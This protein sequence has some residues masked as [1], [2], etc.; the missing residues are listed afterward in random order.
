MD[1]RPELEEGTSLTFPA[2]L[3]D[4]TKSSDYHHV[5]VHKTLRRIH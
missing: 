3:E 5:N 2:L 1:D 4:L